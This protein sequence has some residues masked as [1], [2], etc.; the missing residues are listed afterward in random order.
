VL[1]R[2]A[3]GPPRVEPPT[4]SNGAKASP[5]ADIGI[6]SSGQRAVMQRLVEQ[7]IDRVRLAAQTVPSQTVSSN[8]LAI[9][10]DAQDLD[11]FVPSG[12]PSIRSRVAGHGLHIAVRQL[13]R[14]KDVAGGGGEDAPTTWRQAADWLIRDAA[15]VYIPVIG[16]PQPQPLLKVKDC[17]SAVGA[18]MEAHAAGPTRDV[19]DAMNFLLSR[20]MSAAILQPVRIPNGSWQRILCHLCSVFWTCPL[21]CARALPTLALSQQPRKYLSEADT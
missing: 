1:H 21:S 12:A 6:G 14:R 19:R 7:Y 9:L 10:Q 16:C 4:R 18:V 20:V 17:R 11:G 3:S 2:L 8:V 15:R 13:L 5:G